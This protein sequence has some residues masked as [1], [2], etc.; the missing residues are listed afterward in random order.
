MLHY[1]AW[2]SKLWETMR[3]REAQHAAVHGVRKSQTQLGNWTTI[4]MNIVY[5]VIIMSVPK[6]GI[7]INGEWENRKVVQCYRG[8]KRK[9]SGIFNF[10]CNRSVDI[11]WNCENKKRLCSV[12]FGFME[13]NI[14]RPA[15]N[16]GSAFGKEKLEQC[17]R[18]Q[19]TTIS[20]K[21]GL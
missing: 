3:D 8:M 19:E 5:T 4:A 16:G 10:H 13:V 1:V 14:Q 17:G 12:L 18:G 20:P 6:W 9:V 7:N 2:T 11:T 15:P 21:Q